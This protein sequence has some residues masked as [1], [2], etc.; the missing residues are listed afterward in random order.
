MSAPPPPKPHIF[1][2]SGMMPSFQEQAIASLPTDREA[3]KKT[4]AGSIFPGANCDAIK[5]RL[6]ENNGRLGYT[7]WD[8][9]KYY[10]EPSPQ[11][12][13]SVKNIEQTAKWIGSNAGPG[14]TFAGGFLGGEFGGLPGAVAGVVAG[15]SARQ[16]L[17]SRYAGENKPWDQRIGQ[18]ANAVADE[19]AGGVVG[20]YLRRL[21][22]KGVPFM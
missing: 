2:E 8:G 17:A 11:L 14:L 19:G 9:A 10:A 18:T 20:A 4:L 7:D 1:D 16:L 13:T 21:G 6:F 22:M 15:D 12:P 3:Q 5:D